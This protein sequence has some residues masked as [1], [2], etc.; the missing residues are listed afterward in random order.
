[1]LPAVWRC[2]SPRRMRKSLM[3]FT[4]EHRIAT[5][6]NPKT[7]RRTRC[8]TFTIKVHTTREGGKAPASPHDPTIPLEGSVGSPR[9]NSESDD[10]GRWVGRRRDESP[11]GSRPHR[12]RKS[13]SKLGIPISRGSSVRGCQGDLC[14]YPM[15]SIQPQH[16]MQGKTTPRSDA[17]ASR[18]GGVHSAP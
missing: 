4:Q 18:E 5:R 14:C 17:K 3:C 7:K 2:A 6:R 1:M 12:G 16:M 10:V 8:N 11:F 15:D 13:Q 9:E